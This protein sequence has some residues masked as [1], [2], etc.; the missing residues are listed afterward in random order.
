MHNFDSKGRSLRTK[1][2]M[3]RVRWTLIGGMLIGVSLFAVAGASAQSA[4][5]PVKGKRKPTGRRTLR[6]CA[7]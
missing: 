6:P 4:L 3:R 2:P 5:V 7:L 1:T